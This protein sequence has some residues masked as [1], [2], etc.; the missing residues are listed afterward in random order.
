VGGTKLT[1]E[2]MHPKERVGMKPGSFLHC[3]QLGFFGGEY[4]DTPSPKAFVLAPG[5]APHSFIVR[6]SGS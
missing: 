5:Q 2:K 1:A 3:S 4:S 6:N